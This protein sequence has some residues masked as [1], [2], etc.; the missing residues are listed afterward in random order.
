MKWLLLIPHC[1]GIIKIRERFGL[2]PAQYTPLRSHFSLSPNQLIAK[3][4]AMPSYLHASLEVLLEISPLTEGL[5]NA[6]SNAWTVSGPRDRL[7]KSRAAT[8]NPTGAKPESGEPLLCLMT[9]LVVC[10]VP[11]LEAICLLGVRENAKYCALPQP[12]HRFS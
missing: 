8:G 11:V 12:L 6:L 10:Q 3:S 4:F 5:A 7:P 2:G 9:S 1:F